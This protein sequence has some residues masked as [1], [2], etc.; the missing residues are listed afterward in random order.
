[1]SQWNEG[2]GLLNR[3]SLVLGPRDV[4]GTRVRPVLPRGDSS[5]PRQRIT[6]AKATTTST[7]S[8]T[9]YHRRPAP[10][11][12]GPRAVQSN[13]TFVVVVTFSAAATAADRLQSCK[14]DLCRVRPICSLRLTK[15]DQRSQTSVE[16]SAAA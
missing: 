5:Q 1:V 8:S 12:R 11:V 7:S 6:A 15:S 9:G 13:R 4:P 14:F 3:R 10:A 2:L 16:D